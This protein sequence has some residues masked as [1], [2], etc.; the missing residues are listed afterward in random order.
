MFWLI[1]ADAP[2]VGADGDRKRRR[3]DDD[4]DDDISPDDET[5]TTEENPDEEDS[6]GFVV[7]DDE[8]LGE[9]QLQ[10]ISYLE[11]L[12][13]R[14]AFLGS[15][16]LFIRSSRIPAAG[17]GLFAA[18][19]FQRGEPITLYHGELIDFAEAQVRLAAGQASHIVPLIQF[20]W[21]VDGARHPNGTAITDP[22]AELVGRGLGAYAN[23]VRGT[24]LRENARFDFA[25]TPL[26]QR[27]MDAAVF[28]A[29]ALGP[30]QRQKYV[31]AIEDIAAGQEILLDYGLSGMA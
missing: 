1:A 19:A 18:R 9:V 27:V 3:K 21:Y 26:N 14:P 23:S 6:D 17:L 28:D 10:D 15:N 4:D 8:E 22:V 20:R 24:T 2:L 7:P 29:A 30:N 13:A 5:E 31:R 11:L 12:A 25:D 16:E